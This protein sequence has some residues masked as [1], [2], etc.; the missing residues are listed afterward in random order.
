MT[1]PRA[2]DLATLQRRRD[3]LA[4]QI[5]QSSGDDPGTSHDRREHAALTRVIEAL[6]E[7]K[8]S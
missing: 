5:A 6:R 7:K 3:Y 1:K 4:Q 2:A 8:E